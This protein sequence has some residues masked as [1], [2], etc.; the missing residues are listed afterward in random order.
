MPS[1]EVELC[2]DAKLYAAI[3]QVRENVTKSP[4]DA[5]REAGLILVP[6]GVRVEP[7]GV[8][9]FVRRFKLIHSGGA[10]ADLSSLVPVRR[11][12]KE[13]EA[14][15]ALSLGPAMDRLAFEVFGRSPFAPLIE[16]GEPEP[17][18]APVQNSLRASPGDLD[19]ARGLWGENAG[20]I[21]SM[22]FACPKGESRP[23]WHAHVDR[24][25]D[26]A[27]GRG[28]EADALLE[29]FLW[30]EGASSVGHLVEILALLGETRELAK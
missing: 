18:P 11:H 19:R 5:L 20:E 2:P 25:L 7:R 23:E 27:R 16:P 1:P 3:V 14:D 9:H 4:R 12:E 13:F 29:V 24:V 22:E 17:P 21:T 28:F 8:P 6:S 26:R 30:I 15:V 10:S